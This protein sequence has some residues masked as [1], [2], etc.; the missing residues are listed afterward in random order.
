M[1]N[2]LKSLRT[3]PKDILLWVIYNLM[4]EGKIS[5]HEITKLHIDHLERLQKGAIEDYWKLQG[6]IVHLY[7][8]YKYN[9][10]KNIKDIMQYLNDKGTLNIDQD[11]IDN[12]K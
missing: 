2:I 9:R 10:G 8:D 3:L 6:K 4:E 5:Y 11:K 12:Y 7:N 1:D